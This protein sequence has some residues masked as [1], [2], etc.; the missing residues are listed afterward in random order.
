MTDKRNL[1]KENF[2]YFLPG[3]LIAQTPLPDRTE[4]RLLVSTIANKELSEN[5]FS[6]LPDLLSPGDL[7]VLNNT[8]VFR[9]RLS[10]KRADTGG[11]V[12]AFLLRELDHGIW[13]VLIRPG[14]AARSGIIIEF[15]NDL[16]CTVRQRLGQGRAIIE[17]N[18]VEGTGDILSRTA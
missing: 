15:S 2:Q 17:F 6:N 7:L 1:L 9:A 18:S 4:S 16:S 12:E 10:G 13:K 5:V 3:N 11:K 14:R 8:K